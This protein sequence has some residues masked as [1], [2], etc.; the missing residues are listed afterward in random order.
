MP[1]N[2]VRLLF[3]DPVNLGYDKGLFTGSCCIVA[4]ML[5]YAGELAACAGYAKAIH[6]RQPNVKPR[7]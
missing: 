3:N 4:F 7:E 1:I 2:I 6:R 5:F